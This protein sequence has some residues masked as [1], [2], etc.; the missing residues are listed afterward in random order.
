MEHRDYRGLPR[1]C[2]QARSLERFERRLT[3]PQGYYTDPLAA[4]DEALAD[5]PEFLMGHAFRAALFLVSTERRYLPELAR[6]VSAAEALIA[7]G[8]GTARERAHVSAARAWLDGDFA[9][10]A[11]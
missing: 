2:R 5:E 3:R 7:R 4:I 6:S 11:A 10:A 9:Q 1:S 8:Q